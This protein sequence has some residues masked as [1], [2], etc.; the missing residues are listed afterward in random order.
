LTL[1]RNCLF[2]DDLCRDC[3]QNVKNQPQNR[4]DGTFVKKFIQELEGTEKIPIS[5]DFPPPTGRVNSTLW[6]AHL[7]PNGPPQIVRVLS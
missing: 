7:Y 5:R 1:P 3:Q 2:A 6:L 4:P